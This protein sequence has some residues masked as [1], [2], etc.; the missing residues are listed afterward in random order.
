MKYIV[1]MLLI[2]GFSAIAAPSAADGILRIG[3]AVNGA[4]V[5]MRVLD[6]PSTR[7][8]IV[9]AGSLARLQSVY[10]SLECFVNSDCSLLRAGSEPDLKM[11][12]PEDLVPVLKE[13][14]ENLLGPFE[15]L[16]QT[17]DEIRFR[18]DWSLLKLPFD[19]LYLRGNPVFV[20]K[21]ISYTAGSPQ[22]KIPRAPARHWVGLLV[23][24][25][26]ADPERAIFGIERSFPSSQSF[27][28]AEFGVSKLQE[29]QPVDFVAISGH[30]FVDGDG[31]GFISIG[32]KERLQPGSLMKLRPKLVYFDSCNLGISAEHLK[33]LQNGGTSYAIAP[34][35]S[36]EAGDSSAATIE[37]F[38]SELA[39]GIDPI[40]ALFTARS[41]LHDRYASDDV[42]TRLW[43]SFP[44]RAYQLN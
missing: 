35:W 23:S 22:R 7:S 43:R 8:H 31:G 2:A 11:I 15:D 10:F 40:S 28:I 19:L 16:I 18:I 5:E 25:Q 36:I 3:V 32:Q 14:G 42:R 9:P 34:I 4:N 12:D 30:G 20:S 6:R 21:K 17:A 39:R 27:D 1:S 13:E 26:T 38:F 24:D 37:I 33:Q 41:E 29:I 44:F